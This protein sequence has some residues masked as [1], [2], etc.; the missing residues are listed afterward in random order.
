MSEKSLGADAAAVESAGSIASD[1]A[2]ARHTPGPWRVGFWGGQC[3][4]QRHI[5]D[6]RHPG[7]PACVYEPYFCEGTGIAGAEPNRMVVDTHYDELVISDADAH[8]IAAAPELLE[9]L[10]EAIAVIDFWS[11]FYDREEPDLTEQ[12]HAE[13]SEAEMKRGFYARLQAA[14]AKAEGR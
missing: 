8:L 4:N 9:A 10:R 3:T 14:I 12:L 6:R 5:A 11:K 1:A 7:P 13:M 2:T